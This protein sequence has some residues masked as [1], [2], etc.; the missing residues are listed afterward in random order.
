[1]K[2]FNKK[3]MIVI[4]LIAAAI[5]LA[6]GSAIWGDYR[7]KIMQNHKDQL[8]LTTKALA[9]NMSLTLAE[10]EDDLEFLSEMDK[11]ET[12][13]QI[14]RIFLETQS[15]YDSNL[16]WE[17]PEGT[18]IDSIYETTLEKT[19]FLAQMDPYKSV[20]Q[21]MDADGHC[22]LVVKKQMEDGTVIGLVIDEERYYTQLISDIHIGSNGYVVVKNSSG[23]IVMHPEKR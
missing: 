20:W 11:S 3:N 23:I 12:D 10:Y 6:I 17:D 18:I 16:I 19:A 2:H 22:Y 9:E 5:L 21:Y 8:L 7:D 15:R 14:F 4:P 1:M 13:K